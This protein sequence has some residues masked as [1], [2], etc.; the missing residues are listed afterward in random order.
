VKENS[1]GRRAKSVHPKLRRSR[2]QIVPD[3][4]IGRARP[5]RHTPCRHQTSRPTDPSGPDS[6]P[7][8]TSANSFRL[9]PS[10]FSATYLFVLIRDKPDDK[11]GQAHSH[12]PAQPAQNDNPWRT[13]LRPIRQAQANQPNDNPY[14]SQA[15]PNQ[16]TDPTKSEDN[17]LLTEPLVGLEYTENTNP[18][19]GQE[20]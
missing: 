18:F 1:I 2:R 5:L 8:T 15:P 7:L 6:F 12:Q 14:R 17:P 16:P 11:P 9:I 3:R 19:L 4:P 10:D 20:L 13:R